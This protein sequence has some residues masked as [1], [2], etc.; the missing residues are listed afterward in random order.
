MN[1]KKQTEANAVEYISMV[2]Q[3]AEGNN[4]NKPK[5]QTAVEWLESIFY[6]ESKAVA[7]D[8]WVIL[9]EEMDRII[10]KAKAMEEEQITNAYYDGSQDAPIKVG[11]SEQYY[12]ETYDL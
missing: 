7:F 1:N 12:L 10:E 2:N 6:S 8:K 3:L 5:K 9:E 4:T 11:Q